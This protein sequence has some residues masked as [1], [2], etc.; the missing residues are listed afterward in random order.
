MKNKKKLIGIIA[1]SVLLLAVII[2]GIILSGSKSRELKKQ[3]SLGQQYLSE[4]NYEQAVATFYQAIE[5]D[6]YNVDAYIGIADA[7]LGMEAYEQAKTILEEGIRLFTEN[8]KTEGLSILQGKLDEVQGIIDEILAE[9]ARLKA[10]EEA[11]QKAEEEKRLAEE[12]APKVKLKPLLACLDDLWG[13]NWLEWTPEAYIATFELTHYSEGIND[14]DGLVVKLYR[15]NRFSSSERIAECMG[16]SWTLGRQY[17][18]SGDQYPE[19]YGRIDCLSISP[20]R[21]TYI[22]SLKNEDF[23]IFQDTLYDF[24]KQNGLDSIQGM[25]E[26]LKVSKEEIE[27]TEE[28]RLA[29]DL[30]DVMVEVYGGDNYEVVLLHISDSSFTGYIL[31]SEL[32]GETNLV[33][34]LELEE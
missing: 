26:Y 7:Y 32:V 27:G 14:T 24:A 16:E 6:P 15:E 12:E 4:L 19:S 23:Q 5:M 3:I 29:T 30:G 34:N 13:K 11:R 33:F 22:K 21:T 31:L 9:E 18:I 17:L 1:G 28:F 25:L 8:R 10:E 2:V 20:D